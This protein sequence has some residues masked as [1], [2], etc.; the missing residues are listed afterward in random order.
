MNYTL[1]T[2]LIYWNVFLGA[3]NRVFLKT[4][5]DNAE[6]CRCRDCGR[7]VH[8]YLVDDELWLR[9]MVKEDGVWC[10]DCFCA[11]GQRKGI[12]TMAIIEE[13]P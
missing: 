8:D 3:L 10:W 12:N 2:L 6:C 7:T 4:Y 9:V 13:R 11:R 1:K 5:P